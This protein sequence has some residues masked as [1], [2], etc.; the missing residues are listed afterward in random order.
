MTVNSAIDDILKEFGIPL[1]DGIPYLLILYHGYEPSYIPDSLVQK[2]NRTG[3][4]KK[5]E[6]TNTLEWRLPLFEEQ[7]TQFA[8]VATEYMPLFSEVNPKRKG[9]LKATVSRM[10]KFFSSYPQYRKDDVIGATKMY[11]NNL[12]SPEYI[13]RSDY[14]IKKGVGVNASESLLQWCED[15]ERAKEHDERRQSVTNTMRE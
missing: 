10:K 5:D 15:Y 2:M 14:F 9:P 11:I 12:S 4:Y 6:E 7:L 8:W 1:R 13:M 3:I